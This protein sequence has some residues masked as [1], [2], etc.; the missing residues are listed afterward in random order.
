MYWRMYVEGTLEQHLME[1]NE[2]AQAQVDLIVKRLLKQYPAPDRDEDF[3][4]YVGHMNNL[5]AM[6]E[7]TVLHDL[8]YT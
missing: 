1:I 7:E 2:T 6:A 4:S 8:I 3:L 5:T